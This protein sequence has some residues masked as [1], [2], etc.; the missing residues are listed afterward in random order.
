MFTWKKPQRLLLV[1]AL[2]I[3]G[4]FSLPAHSDINYE[5]DAFVI[6]DCP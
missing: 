1:P 5:L 6:T 3:I 4:T 2:A